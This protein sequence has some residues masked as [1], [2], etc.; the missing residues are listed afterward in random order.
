MMTEATA[1]HILPVLLFCISCSVT[2]GPNNLMIMSSGLNYGVRASLRHFFGICIGFTFMMLV[3]GLGLGSVFQSF[4]IMGEI[5]KYV[6]MVYLLYLAWKIAS[7]SLQLDSVQSQQ[8]M[9]FMQAMI[10][11]W[12]NPKAWVMIVSSISAY[13]SEAFPM[14]SPEG[15]VLMVTLIFL[16]VGLPCVAIWLFFGALLKRVLK[17]PAA[18]KRFNIAMAALLVISVVW[19]V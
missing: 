5:I 9:G 6:G 13:A 3:V 4:P 1:I 16:V 17:N 8:P 10:F 15:Q 19:V 12:V 7:S 14:L 18:Q 11:Q 2:P